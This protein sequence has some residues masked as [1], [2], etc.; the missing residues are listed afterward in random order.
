MTLFSSGCGKMPKDHASVGV[1][2]GIGDREY[3]Q[4]RWGTSGS[5]TEYGI[6]AVVADGMGGLVNSDQVSSTLVESMLDAYAPGGEEDPQRILRTLLQQ[7]VFSVQSVL[8]GNSY[9]S[10]STVISCLIRGGKL[11]FLSAGD[12]RLY[13]WRTGGLIQLNR[14]HDFAYELNMMLLRGEITEESADSNPR[15]GALTSFVGKDFPQK[16]DYNPE[17]IQ[18]LRGDRLL[19]CSD[20]VYRALE[21][22]ELSR[23]LRKDAVSAAKSIERSIQKK[24]LPHQD[25]FT[26]IVIQIS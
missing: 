3:Q 26:A 20:G 13:L 5:S 10:G 19:L 23:F 24:K 14:D 21:E 8:E 16:L 15:K 22:R 6:L 2:H 9:Q 25:N 1:V 12:S 7:A 11:S 4:D 18:L 17:P